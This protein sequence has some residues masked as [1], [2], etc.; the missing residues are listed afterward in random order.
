MPDIKKAIN[1]LRFQLNSKEVKEQHYPVQ[2]S[3]SDAE[4]IIALLEEQKPK[5]PIHIH[6]EHA[7]H[8]WKT[9]KAGKIDEFAMDCGFHHGP[10]CKRCGYTFCEH[11]SPNGWNWKPCVVDYYLCPRCGKIIL[12]NDKNCVN[13]EQAVKWE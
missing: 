10:A 4:K 11:C 8:D 7:E 5:T 2:L 1:E 9:D 6:R 12:K 3:A 13:C